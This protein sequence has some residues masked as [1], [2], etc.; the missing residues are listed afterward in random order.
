[1][2]ETI[3]TK[4]NDIPYSFVKTEEEALERIYASIKSVLIV[5]GKLG[6][7]I[8]PKIR[9][10]L[11]EVSNLTGVIVYCGEKHVPKFTREL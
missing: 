3:K 8:L 4:Y 2:Q 5:S 1:M 11:K 7:K 6:A 10:G 9:N